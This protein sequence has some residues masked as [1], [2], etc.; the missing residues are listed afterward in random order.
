MLC[1]IG[2]YPTC[3]RPWEARERG[4]GSLAKLG[5]GDVSDEWWSGKAKGFQVQE[6]EDRKQTSK[7][8][9]TRRE[10]RLMEQPS[11]TGQPVTQEGKGNLG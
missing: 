6:M 3:P 9:G 5:P 4:T 7:V 1:G 2:T 10:I 11:C 8:I